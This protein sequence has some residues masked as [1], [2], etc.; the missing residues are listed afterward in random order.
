[1][2]PTAAALGGVDRRCRNTL[3]S[4]RPAAPRD[5]TIAIARSLGDPAAA[6]VR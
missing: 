4:R 5:S 1:L 2:T 3:G 6:L